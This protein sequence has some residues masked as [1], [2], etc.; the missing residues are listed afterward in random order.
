MNEQIIEAQTNFKS[1][2]TSSAHSTPKDHKLAHACLM[3]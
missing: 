1:E 2:S 3:S